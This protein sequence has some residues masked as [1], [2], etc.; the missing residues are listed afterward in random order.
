[1]IATQHLITRNEFRMVLRELEGQAGISEVK[2]R[3]LGELWNQNYLTV[4]KVD[5]GQIVLKENGN[6]SSVRV[7][8]LEQVVQVEFKS[9]FRSYQP[10]LVYGVRP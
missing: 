4:V 10:D 8:N 5:E 7:A 2:V 6:A 1:M 3:E 9:G